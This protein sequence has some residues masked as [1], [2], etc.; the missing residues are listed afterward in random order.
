MRRPL[1]FGYLVISFVF[2]AA[3]CTTYILPLLDGSGLLISISEPQSLTTLPTSVEPVDRRM[4]TET[5]YGNGFSY[6]RGFYFDLISFGRPVPATYILSFSLSGF[7]AP[8]CFFCFINTV[9]FILF[10]EFSFF[11]H[12]FYDFILFSLLYLL[13][14]SS[15]LLIF[16]SFSLFYCSPYLPS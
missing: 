11:D 15:N 14:E 6:M 10:E 13:N 2:P 4:R 9:V 8:S 16:F 3:P 5:R 7:N 1:Y 12:V